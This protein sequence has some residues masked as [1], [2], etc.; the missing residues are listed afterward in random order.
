MD[1]LEELPPGIRMGCGVTASSVEEAT[2]LVQERVFGGKPL[3]QL[4]E[5]VTDVDVSA[6]DPS[7]VRVNMGNPVLRGIWFPLGY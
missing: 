6:L 2:A 1:S 4:R 5:V 7:H 3:P